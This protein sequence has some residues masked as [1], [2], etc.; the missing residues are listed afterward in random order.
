ME[1]WWGNANVKLVT[2]DFETY[3]DAVYT[4][5]K[6]GKGSMSTSEYVRDKRF[7]AICASIKVDSGKAKVSWG[8][9]AIAKALARI[10]WRE[11]ELLAHHAHFEGLILSHHFGI[12]PARYRD[13]LSMARAVFPKT[14]RNDLGTLTERLGVQNKLLMPEFKG[15]RL[16]DFDKHL[17]AKVGEYVN[18][19]VESCYQAYGKM[20]PNFPASELELINITVRMFAEPVLKLNMKLAKVELKREQ[21]EQ[22]AAIS[23]SGALALLTS[24]GITPK[25]KKKGDVVTDKEVLSSNKL[26]PEALR[27]AGIEPPMKVSKTTGRP[28]YALAK[29]DEDFTDL[30]SHP[31][32][33]V[34][35]LVKGRLAAKS[36]IGE[37]RAARLIRS[38]SGG[39]KLP[40]YL[41]YFGAHT[42]RWSGGD[43][44]NYQNLKKKGDIRR[45]IL[46]P[47]GHKLVVIDS[48]QIEA[49]VVA[50]LA[51]EQWLLEAFRNK[52]DVY[53]EFA[54]VA[55]GRVVTKADKTERFVGKTC[56]LGL[57]FQ[58]GA[59]KLQKGL[60][61]LSIQQ[62]LE[63]VRLELPE[64]YKLVNAYRSKNKNIVALWE[65]LQNEVISDLAFAPEGES[66]NYKSISWGREY[67]G[68]PNGLVLHYPEARA[69]LVKSNAGG[70]GR[71]TERVEDAS[72]RTIEGRTKMYGGYLTEN[73]VQALARI[74]VA[75][76]M[77]KIGEKYRIVMMTHDEIVFMVPSKEADEALK[78]GLEVMH[79]PPKW[80]PDLPVAAEGEYDDFY[81]K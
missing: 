42:G 62:G 16:V 31:N 52:R 2:V 53:S 22:A 75:E 8:H 69:R 58:M 64:C 70:L 18:G 10:D 47:A 43:K 73:V 44:L 1:R 17:K 50:W 76:Q 38:G 28:T 81:S 20:L 32:P 80:A 11:A 34:S 29:A 5:K 63:P 48:A 30:I 19:D 45:A 55:Y 79:T 66:R 3:Y 13:T 60:V 33:K 67:I 71:A 24:A 59:P 72:Y 41:N 6:Q 37:T 35:D 21:D 57:G 9:A 78:W 25:P 51:G 15:K 68:L 56:V 74:I 77:L 54:T 36:T 65:Y 7:E 40:V 46:A 61:T 4:L 23:G 39:K 27:L 49:R 26:F 14:E 12:T